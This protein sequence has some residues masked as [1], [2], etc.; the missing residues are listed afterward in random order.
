M[1]NLLDYI[2]SYKLFNNAFVLVLSNQQIV[3]LDITTLILYNNSTQRFKMLFTNK[4]CL[5]I[6]CRRFDY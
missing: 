5:I 1:K 2:Q 3:L 6:I 4:K